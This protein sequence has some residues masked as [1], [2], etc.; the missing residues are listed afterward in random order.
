MMLTAG[1]AIETVGL[2]EPPQPVRLTMK[3]N[4]KRADR[5]RSNERVG[6]SIEPPINSRGSGLLM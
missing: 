3:A 6:R 1:V 5:T 4:E 2:L